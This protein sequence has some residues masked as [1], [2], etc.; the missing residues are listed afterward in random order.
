MRS[1]SAVARLAAVAAAALLAGCTSVIGGTG[2]RAGSATN[3]AS[4]APR[5]RATTAPTSPIT[6]SPTADAYARTPVSTAIGDPVT[7][8]LCTAIGL[9][10]MQSAVTGLTPSFDGRQFPPGC[11]VTYFQGAVAQFGV[12]VFADSAQPRSATGRSTRTKSGQSV[13][14]YPFDATNGRCERDVV[15][16]GVLLV[17]DATPQGSAKPD[18]TNYCAAT[19]AMS[20]RLAAVLA[21]G[22]VPRLPL[23]HPSVSA[24]DACKVVRA[25]GITSLSAFAKGVISSQGFGASCRVHPTGLFLFVN[26]VV[27][28]AAQPGGSTLTTVGGH[29]LYATS[30]SSDF[31]SYAS[32]QGTTSDGHHEQLVFAATSTDPA[33]TPAGLCNQTSQAAA[34]YLDTVGLH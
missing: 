18:K 6:T 23:A 29:S 24:I 34:K 33:K 15:G 20:T 30:T 21:A 3:S 11:S 7:A 17:V 13:Y 19:D 5:T 8:D 22:N 31:C 16:R 1:R 25:A 32:T 10:V 9:T 26:L 14:V 28:D 4:S 27:A 2:H 12:S